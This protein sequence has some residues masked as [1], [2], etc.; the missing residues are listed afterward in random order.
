[1]LARQCACNKLPHASFLSVIIQARDTPINKQTRE[2]HNKQSVLFT[3]KLFASQNWSSNP[4]NIN[5]YPMLPQLQAVKNKY[6]DW[7][8]TKGGAR[9]QQNN[10]GRW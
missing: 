4:Q 8:A 9:T 5:N 3:K 10:S 7:M 1:M 6:I 2:L